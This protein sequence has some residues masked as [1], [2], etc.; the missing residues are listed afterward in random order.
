M[1][2]I[3]SAAQVGAWL[4]TK[5]RGIQVIDDQV[6]GVET[7]EGGITA[8]TLES[9]QRVA[10][11][12]FV[13]CTGFRRRLIGELGAEWQSFRDVLPVNRAMPFWVDLKEGE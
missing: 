12:F 10:G 13:D 1:R 8:L 7:G 5:A 11:D 3:A 2:C 4:R 6:T 9:G